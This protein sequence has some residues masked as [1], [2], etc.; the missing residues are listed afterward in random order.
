MLSD[1]KMNKKLKSD[2][3]E[4]LE[5]LINFIKKDVLL[6]YSSWYIFKIDLKS[7]IKLS[8]QISISVSNQTLVDHIGGLL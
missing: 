1:I 8:P 6:K 7:L 3:L 5:F 2:P 4:R